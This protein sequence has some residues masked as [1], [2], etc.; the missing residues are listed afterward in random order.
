MP[1][2]KIQCDLELWSQKHACCFPVGWWPTDDWSIPVFLETS[3]ND[4][5][6]CGALPDWTWGHQQDHVLPSTHSY[7]STAPCTPELVF[8]LFSSL[9]RLQW[10]QLLLGNSFSNL[11]AVYSLSRHK[12]LIKYSLLYW[13]ANS[14]NVW[15]HVFSTTLKNCRV[16][17]SMR[18]IWFEVI[19]AFKGQNCIQKNYKYWLKFLH[20]KEN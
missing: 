19:N 15:N 1:I 12:F 17:K 16:E 10:F 3:N 5:C 7:W 6:H 13:T 8:N 11:C 9:R 18:E 4:S 20:F 14:R 2:R